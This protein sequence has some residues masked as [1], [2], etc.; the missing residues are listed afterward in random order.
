MVHQFV[1]L[2]LALGVSRQNIKKKIGNQYTTMWQGRTN[3]QRQAWE[4]I[5]DARPA[6]KNRLLSFVRMQSRVVTG[7]L[8]GC[9][10]LRRRFYIMGVIDSPL[11]WRC[12]A[13]EDTSAHIFMS[14]TVVT[15][16]HTYLGSF[17]WT[18]R[19]VEV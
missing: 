7:L 11:C 19:M 18:Q 2:E 4:L 8:T 10:T 3:T 12:G 16:G 6:S 15:L 1:G 13:E 5:S 14:E 17:F 9:N